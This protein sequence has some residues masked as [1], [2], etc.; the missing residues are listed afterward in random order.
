MSPEAYE[1]VSR[2]A[3]YEEDERW[4]EAA[5]ELQRALPFD[6][7]A[8]EVRAHLA[9]LFVRLGRLDDAADEVKRSLEIAPTVDGYL[10]EAHLAE[11]QP[12]EEKRARAVPALRQAAA[13]A[14]EGTIPRRSSGPTWSSPT[15][16]SSPW[17]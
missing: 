14:L 5:E 10:A 9:E 4:Q 17:I 12:T 13:L 3:L 11:A 8:A 16:R 7:E 2:A 1:H 6:P 15:R